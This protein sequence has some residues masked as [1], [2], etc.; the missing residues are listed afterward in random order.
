MHYMYAPET[1]LQHNVALAEAAVTL[2]STRAAAEQSGAQAM[3]RVLTGG[4]ARAAQ[5]VLL[6]NAQQGQALPAA[7]GACLQ[8]LRCW[9][10]PPSQGSLLVHRGLLVT[11]PI[12][13]RLCCMCSLTVRGAWACTLACAAPRCRAW[14]TSSRVTGELCRAHGGGVPEFW[15][16][17]SPYHPGTRFL[18]TP[19]D[20]L[21]VRPPALQ[22]L[23]PKLTAPRTLRLSVF[24]RAPA[25][26]SYLQ[27]L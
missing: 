23:L 4:L 21:N 13:G 25:D 22:F 8:H 2:C 26:C 17:D 10:C 1:L 19:P 12:P 16:K 15:G 27:K 11:C 20:H 6:S 3:S 9:P 24:T 5:G 18:G 14:S 7:A